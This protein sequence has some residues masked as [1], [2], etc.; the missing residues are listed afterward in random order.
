[1]KKYEEAIY[2]GIRAASLAGNNP[3]ALLYRAGNEPID[4]EL[5]GLPVMIKHHFNCD[6]WGVH[7]TELMPYPLFANSQNASE[8]EAAFCRAYDDTL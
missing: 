4:D 2:A 8:A 5:C 7:N 6:D 1:M 3:V